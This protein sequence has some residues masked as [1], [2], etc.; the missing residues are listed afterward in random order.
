MTS[1]FTNKCLLLLFIGA[2]SSGLILTCESHAQSRLV[3]AQQVAFRTAAQIA[4]AGVPVDFDVRFYKITYRTTGVDGQPDTASGALA[5]PDTSGLVLPM[6]SYQHGTVFER[7]DVPSRVNSESDIGFVA[8]GLGYAVCLPDYLGL[9]D[10]RGFHP[11]LHAETQARAARHLLEAASEYAAPNGVRFS[12]RLFISGYSQ[13]GHATAA[14][15]E[16]LNADPLDSFTLVASAPLS[17][18]YDMSGITR[19]DLL[20]SN[21]YPVPAYVPYLLT[22]YQQQYGN[23]FQRP[24][25]VFQ[26]PF[27]S[28]YAAALSGQDIDLARLNA[29]LPR[30]P[31]RMLDSA[32]VMAVRNDSQHPLN[33]ALRDNDVYDFVPQVPTRFFYCGAD[34]QVAPRN[35]IFTDSLMNARGAVNVAS[36]NL[37]PNFN[38]GQCVNPA[39]LATFA[40]FDSIAV[41]LAGQAPNQRLTQA[42]APW[43]YYDEQG[44]VRNH[45][46]KTLDFALY[47]L[48]GRLLREGRLQPQAQL[49]QGPGPSGLYIVH[50]QDRRQGWSRTRKVRLGVSFH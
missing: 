34:R 23:L 47:D 27:D 50:L 20:D 16:S 5:L 31:V 38:H 19:N 13:G 11:Y 6:L 43:L 45:Y 39:F 15:H 2:M 25:E 26:P 24:S 10:S 7:D 18:P 14:L 37:N 3:T 46:G 44:A 36:R 49:K 35:S 41:Q 8:A 30:A 33:V 32:F 1:I 17:G 29:Q 21:A 28:L 4:Q 48:Q 12:G 22:G 42:A 9:G 40:F